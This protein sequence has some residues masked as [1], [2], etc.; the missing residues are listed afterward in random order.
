MPSLRYYVNKYITGMEELT[1]ETQRSTVKPQLANIDTPYKGYHVDTL[2]PSLLRRIALNEPLTLKAMYKK[3]KDTI[4]N[5][6]I[7]KHIEQDKEVPMRVQTLIRNF[8][9]RTQLKNKL[10]TAGVCANMY[11]TGFLERTFVESKNNDSDSP[12]KKGSKPLNLIP[13]SSEFITKK[14]PHPKKKDGLMY[15]VYDEAPNEVRYI[16]PDRV[17]DVSIDKLPHS[18]FGISKVNVLMNILK[19]KMNAD[20]S[21]GEILNWFG[22][23]ILDM[24]INHMSPEEQKAMIE[25]FKKHPSYY[26]HNED[27]VLDVKN[28]TNID[29][30]PF[31]EYFYNNIAAAFEI[32][33]NILIGQQ[34]GNVTGSEIGISDYYN[35]IENIQEVVFTPIIEKIYSNLLETNG[36]KWD[37]KIIWNPIFVD[38][39]S[40]AKILQTR[41]YSAVQDYNSGIVDLP[42]A[43]TILNDGV[44]SLDVNKEIE[45]KEQPS[46]DTVPTTDPN[47]EPQP[48]DKKPKVKNIGLERITRQQIEMICEAGRIEMEAQE[49][50]LREAE[51]RMK[52]K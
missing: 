29:P 7:V 45:K 37:Y 15:F 27:Y 31:Y 9:K 24:T 50:R 36:M 43:R 52:G 47:V 21:S 35:D 5:W 25:L 33:T 30:K 10:F 2:A 48:T 20:R 19:S 44:L 41:T 13:L 17:I 16:H 4:R 26:V 8:E 23:G 22:H 42:E 3:N 34:I 1:Q 49:K 18:P 6:L 11:G 14:E 28:P 12:V 51:E 38:E 40:E 32:P 39:L 46:D